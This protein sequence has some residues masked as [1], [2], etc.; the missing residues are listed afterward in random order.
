MRQ[1]QQSQLD[2][3]RRV[4]SFLDLHA[5]TV[6]S[7]KDSAARAQLDGAVAQL[8]AHGNDQSTSDL[9]MKGQ[10]NREKSLVT[11]LKTQHMQPIATFARA[12]LRGVPDFAA[13][14]KPLSRLRGTAL[15]RAA[16][17]M[18]T[19]AAPYSTTL[20]TG[21]F[22]ADTIAQLT[23]A[24]DVLDGAI[25][26]RANTKV[27]R[28]GATKGISQQVLLGREAISMLNA[29]I[30]RQF[31]S[32]KTFLAGWRAA[33]RVVAKPGAVAGSGAVAG[34]ATVATATAK[35]P[36]T[37]SVVSMVTAALPAPSVATLLPPVA[38]TASDHV[39]V[40]VAGGA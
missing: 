11:D 21:G 4:Q 38:A 8:T 14:T 12:K 31:A 33:H 34:P 2:S 35:S 9:V 22:P 27:G 37:A 30:G 17:A 24:A 32:D 3:F 39:A 20:T 40:S 6:G 25:T 16:R 10:V 7:L 29:V 19:A 13:F 15:V 5:D 28:V 23:A 36:T 26:D 1:Q 18:A